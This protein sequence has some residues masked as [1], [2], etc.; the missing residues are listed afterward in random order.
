MSG[1]A[2]SAMVAMADVIYRQAF[3]AASSGRIQRT[4]DIPN[5]EYTLD[6]LARLLEA[7]TRGTAAGIEARK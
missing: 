1:I 6:E 4:P 5:G 2:E 7:H 3:N